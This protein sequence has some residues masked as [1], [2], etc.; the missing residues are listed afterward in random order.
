[1]RD[2]ARAEIRLH[3]AAAQV[4]FGHEVQGAWS[5]RQAYQQMQATVK[6]YPAYLPARKTLGLMQFLLARCPKA[7][8]GF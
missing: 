2:Y 6:R 5:M 8:A 3:Q 1:L 7:T 4:A